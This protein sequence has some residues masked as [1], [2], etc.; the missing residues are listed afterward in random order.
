MDNDLLILYLAKQLDK[1]MKNI[2]KKELTTLAK[3][4]KI[5]LSNGREK[6]HEQTERKVFSIRYRN[7]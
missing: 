2:L 4:D 7:L 6:K 1:E 5:N 3:S